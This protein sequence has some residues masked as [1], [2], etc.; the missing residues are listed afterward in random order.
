MPGQDPYY[1]H[2]CRVNFD[3]SDLTILTEGDGTHVAQ[4]SPDRKFLIDTWS[5]VDLPPVT[6]LRRSDD[7]KLI[8]DLEKADTSELD[9]SGWKPP[10]RFVAKGRDGVTDIYGVILRPKN[11]DPQRKYPVIEDIYAGPQDSFMPK[12]FSRR[13]IGSRNWPTAD[14]SS[15]KWTAWARRIA[16]K[17]FTMSA[18]KIWRTPVFP[19][20]FCGSKRRRQSIR[21]WI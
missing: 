6:Q 14:S 7:G 12:A 20:A 5:R 19:I 9:A 2:Y 17:N 21:A 18:G 3:G 8:C 4:F 11:F 13:R 1:V 10:E 15:C 16:R